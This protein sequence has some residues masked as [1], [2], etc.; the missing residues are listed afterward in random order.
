MIEE[1][2][3]KEILTVLDRSY[4]LWQSLAQIID[5]RLKYKDEVREDTDNWDRIC[6]SSDIINDTIRAIE[7]YVKSDYPD[8]DIGLQ[9]IF[10]YGLLQAL[11][12]QQD[13]VENLFKVLHKCYPQD[14]KFLYKP[15]NELK[16]VRELR[17]ETTG[18]PTGTFD[19]IFTYINRGLGKWH[20]KRLRSSKAGGNE[21]PHVDLFSVLKKQAFAIKNDLE[22]LVEKLN[23]E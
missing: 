8:K 13:S 12:L 6:S 23:E 16:E 18:H 1:T 21:F 20:F 9:Y 15:S 17:N 2:R 7:S 5:Q 10:I 19:G 14:Q 22:I 3:Q 11:Y 4:K